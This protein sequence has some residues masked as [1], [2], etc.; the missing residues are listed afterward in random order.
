MGQICMGEVG[1]KAPD[2]FDFANSPFEN[3]GVDFGGKTILQ[4]TSAGTQG[5]VA[6]ATK[7]D[8]LYAASLVTAEA[9]VRASQAPRSGLPRGYGRE[10]IETN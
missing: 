10:R 9:T 1:G 2:G 5:I 4:R 6:A 7:G 3:S 8:R